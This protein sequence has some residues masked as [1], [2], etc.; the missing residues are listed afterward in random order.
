MN[1]RQRNITQ[2]KEWW[3]VFEAEAEKAGMC[4][5][6]WMGKR[7]IEGGKKLK[8]KLPERTTRGRPV[9]KTSP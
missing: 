8:V 1:K 5:S 9:K 4:L 6:E 7:C 2:P 3:A